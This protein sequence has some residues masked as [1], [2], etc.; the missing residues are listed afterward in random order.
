MRIVIAVDWSDQTF[1]A[2]QVAG[3]LFTPDELTL[4]HGIDMRP[5]ESPFTPVP[6]AKQAHEELR[7]AL[8]DAGEKL[9]DQTAALVPSSVKSVRRLYQFGNPADVILE[10]AKSA[11]ADLIVVGSRGRGR[12]AEAVLGSVSHR[13]VQHASCSTLIVRADPGA[14]THAVLA[15][16]GVEDAARLRGWLSANRLARSVSWSVISVVPTP[17]VGDPTLA[18]GYAAWTEEMEH[19]AQGQVR[20]TATALGGIYHISST[21]VLKGDPADQIAEAAK[22]AQL[23]VI[24]SHGRR[25][26]ER[27]LLGSVS[28]AVLHH[29]SCPV[30]VIR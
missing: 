5:F 21:Q 6:L 11:K 24:G 16:E 14:V 17:H 28:H 27:F 10:T 19:Y 15:I 22:D 4:I 13:V 12:M 8:I 7:Q 29:V 3:R 2:V 23:V 25:G 20:E 30:L 1:N 26:V 9:L 18:Y